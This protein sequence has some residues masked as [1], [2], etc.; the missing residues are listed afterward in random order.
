MTDSHLM[1]IWTMK[2]DYSGQGYV[3]A[4]HLS[5]SCHFVL[6]YYSGIYA[7]VGL[8]PCWWLTVYSC[9]CIFDWG[10]FRSSQCDTYY[11]TRIPFWLQYFW[12]NKMMHKMVGIGWI[13]WGIWV[14]LTTWRSKYQISEI[15]LARAELEL[16]T[17]APQATRFMT[18]PPLLRHKG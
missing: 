7:H 15:V 10:I 12:I 5:V 14:T 13:V 17:P 3:G 1:L 11:K 4:E 16:R 8:R 6:S 2:T 18:I 9:Y